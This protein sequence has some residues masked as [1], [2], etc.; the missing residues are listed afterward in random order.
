M[1]QAAAQRDPDALQRLVVHYHDILRTAVATALAPELRHRIDPDDVLQQ[2]YIAAFQALCG[3][4]DDSTGPTIQFDTPGGFYKWLERIALNTLKDQ[5]RALN[6]QKRDIHREVPPLADPRSSYPDLLHRL[7]AADTTPSRQ[8]A[9]DE[10]VA[11][12][13]TALARLTA[14]QRMVVR[15]RF[16]EGR[17]I[18]DIAAE[19]DKNESAI[20]MLCHRGLKALREH[21]ASITRYLTHL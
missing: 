16:L 5:Q 8:F 9:R 10:A 20:H 21:I 17:E 14:D 3:R 2:T 1:V 15:L 6:R 11:A 13:M 19:L 12:V 4:S 18:A 7:T